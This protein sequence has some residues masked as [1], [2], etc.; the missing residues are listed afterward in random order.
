[1]VRSQL[2]VRRRPMIS[3]SRHRNQSDR[4]L[5]GPP[6][7]GRLAANSQWEA[8]QSTPLWISCL[9]HTRFLGTAKPTTTDPL[10][11]LCVCLLEPDELQETAS[12][13]IVWHVTV[14]AGLVDAW[15]AWE[16]DVESKENTH[17]HANT[18]SLTNE[19]KRN[20]FW[21]EPGQSTALPA[22]RC[23]AMF[24]CLFFFFS[25]PFILEKQTRSSLIV[26]SS[27]FLPSLW[28]F[29]FFF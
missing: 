25:F 26:C 12:H 7:M 22:S 5:F 18:H 13:L 28:F 3:N 4:P 20:D 1:M 8:R 16:S 23:G 9:V 29:Y 2:W 17:T 11:F 10:C 27:S 19:T 21:N 14:P 6:L 24:N 15:P